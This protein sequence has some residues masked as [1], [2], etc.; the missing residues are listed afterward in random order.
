MT[1]KA[2]PPGLDQI[3]RE[4]VR[5]ATRLAVGLTALPLLGLAL[6]SARRDAPLAEASGGEDAGAGDRAEIPREKPLSPAGT[7]PDT[8]VPPEVEAALKK[9]AE[10][11]VA[12]P[13]RPKK[14]S[15][16]KGADPEPAKAAK[17]ELGRKAAIPK[18]GRGRS[19]PDLA[20]GYSGGGR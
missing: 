15:R 18:G 4:G 17:P 14:K 12:R 8:D 13:A 20:A 9:L 2:R 19:Q 5:L 3:A 10:A 16:P 1:E 7:N 6:L 11:T